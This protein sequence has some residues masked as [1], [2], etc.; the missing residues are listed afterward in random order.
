LELALNCDSI[1]IDEV[2]PMELQSG[3]FVQAVE[4]VVESEKP[5]LAIV[6]LGFDHPL[7]QNIR[8]TFKIIIVTRE[9]R[10]TLPVEVAEELRMSGFI[11]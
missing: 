6:K 3:K 1:V 8:R 2:G 10:D 9:N 7:A 4:K 11:N 5:I